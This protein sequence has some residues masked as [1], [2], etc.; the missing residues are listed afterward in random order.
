MSL[1][2]CCVCWFEGGPRSEANAVWEAIMWRSLGTPV[3]V[4]L[5]KVT[6]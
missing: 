2:I 4:C 6:H 3:L 1:Y 5:S